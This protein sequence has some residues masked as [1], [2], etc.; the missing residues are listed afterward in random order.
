MK[1]S[2][3]SPKKA[4][5]KKAYAKKVRTR[6]LYVVGSTPISGQQL[7]IFT[8]HAKRW[9]I[10]IDSP[11]VEVRGSIGSETTLDSHLEFA[12]TGY[13]DRMNFVRALI[14][15]DARNADELIVRSLTVEAPA[16]T[17]SA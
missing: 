9:D 1:F 17:T 8:T 3:S 2:K 4:H 16:S 13:D 11:S 6:D 14:V 10:V 5:A 15:T 12:V 7:A